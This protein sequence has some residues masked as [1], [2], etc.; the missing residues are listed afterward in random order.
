M[1]ELDL[2][3]SVAELA[4][5]LVDI[6]SVSGDEAAIADVVEAALARFGHLEVTRSGDA[7]VA[8][9]SLDRERRVLVAGH[10]DTVP[11]A[12]NV[13]A[14]WSA[15]GTELIGRG[16]VDM[17]AGLAV[18]VSLA[19]ALDEP[20]YDISWIFYDNEEVEAP[21][22]GLG[23]LAREHADLLAGDFAVLC[24]PTSAV[25]EGGCNGTLRAEV[26]L[27]GRAAH[28][29][30]AWKGVNAIH[31]AGS[32]LAGLAAYEA[33]TITVDGLDYREGISA[34]GIRGGIA[35]N[36][37]PDECIVTINYRFA[38]QWSLAEA[39][40]RLETV[41]AAAT[42]GDHSV[43]FVDEA[44]AARP[45]L[46][47]PL[48]RSFVAAVAA[49]GAGAPRAKLGWT[50]VARFGALGIP[51]VNFGPGDPELAH[52][53]DERCLVAD[54]EA[55]RAALAAWLTT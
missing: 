11:I 41:V 44:D 50:D 12:G 22:N 31:R 54:I 19:A 53:D 8:R 4:R 6:P 16:S 27:A 15:D 30:R 51:A 28:S 20:A 33:A 36:V 34:V 23:R 29:A 38:P 42:V 13:P 2:D 32:L 40:Q 7:V 9:T 24:E 39:K 21:R 25:I 14:R 55:C 37:V 47:D 5:Q 35:G 1:T 26:R 48:A 45:G 49:T 46:D 18:M 43:S 52:S 3:A 17:K 10:L